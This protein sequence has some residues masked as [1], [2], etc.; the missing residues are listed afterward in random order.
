MKADLQ[1]IYTGNKKDFSHLTPAQLMGLTIPVGAV[2]RS[3][4]TRAKSR[5]K[6]Y[7]KTRPRYMDDY[8]DEVEEIYSL[9]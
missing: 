4:K 5:R 7:M 3:A 1:K 6:G 9:Q 2:R 8:M